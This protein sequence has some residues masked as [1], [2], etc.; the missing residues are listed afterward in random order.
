[1]YGESLTRPRP[2]GAARPETRETTRP[3]ARPRVRIPARRAGRPRANYCRCAPDRRLSKSSGWGVMADETSGNP[4]AGTT[5]TRGQRTP[6]RRPSQ[7]IDELVQRP[8][9]NRHG[10]APPRCKD[11]RRRAALAARTRVHRRDEQH[12]R[13]EGHPRASTTH[14]RDSFFERLAQAVDHGCDELGELVEKE[15]A[16]RRESYADVP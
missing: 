5:T 14:S 11:T 15:H 1:M 6:R 8:V 4:A 12:L 3:R 16:M 9:P 10:D 2:Q 7:H 13:G